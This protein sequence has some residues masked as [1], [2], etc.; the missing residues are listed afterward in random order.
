MPDVYLDARGFV[1]SFNAGVLFLRP[2][3]LLYTQML[4][5]LSTARYEREYAEQA[6]LNV[7][8]GA[9]AVRLPYA[10]NGNLALKAR[11]RGV[12]E[13]IRKEM[14]VVHYTIVKPFV[15]HSWKEVGEGEVAERVREAAREHGGLFEEEMGVWGRMWEETRVGYAEE[16]RRCR[17]RV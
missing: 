8:F 6:F 10:Y 4:A 13:G 3:S 15:S 2:S 14:R 5:H 1:T 7:F 17:A 11:S 9:D 12:W 16:V